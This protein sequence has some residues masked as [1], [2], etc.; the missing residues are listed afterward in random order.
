MFH[1]DGFNISWSTT[2]ETPP[3]KK[4]LWQSLT[5]LVL[6]QRLRYCPR[7]SESIWNSRI[8]PH[9]PTN[10]RSLELLSRGDSIAANVL[11][12]DDI[13]A[14]PSPM[15]TG[16]TQLE[17]R[18]KELQLPNLEVFR[19]MDATLANA[20][21]L[22]P[23]LG[24]AAQS[25]AL[26]VLELTVTP[27]GGF[28][29]FLASLDNP[30]PKG[31]QLKDMTFLHSANLHTLGLRDFNFLRD[32][33]SRYGDISGFDGQDFLDWIDC[34]PKLHTVSVYPGL[35]QGVASFIVKLILHPRV[36]VIHQVNLKGAEWAEVSEL[37]KK[38]GVKLHHTPNHMPVGWPML[39]D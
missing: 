28:E 30:L 35:W 39:E 33:T 26:K 14:H 13:Q 1:L 10:L 23:I 29:Q 3:D 7:A 34:F 36:K 12:V 6:G 22:E 27:F 18:L 37:A 25:G 11:T 31:V 4:R 20:T 2:K 17:A 21:L 9:L 19:C 16:G 5:H 38:N 32:L 8:L 15:M 24:P